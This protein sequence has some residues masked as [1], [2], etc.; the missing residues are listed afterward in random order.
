MTLDLLNLFECT[1]A[2]TA[3]GVVAFEGVVLSRLDVAARR[4]WWRMG[5]TSAWQQA[6]IIACSALFP[7]GMAAGIVAHSPWLAGPTLMLGMAGAAWLD[8]SVHSFIVH[9][10][11]KRT[12]EMEHWKVRKPVEQRLAHQAALR[13]R[14]L[15]RVQAMSLRRLMDPHFLFNALNGIMHDMMTLEWER[16]L[17]H[18]RAFNRLAKHQIQAGHEG[19]RS[20]EDEWTTLQDYIGL[21]VRRLARPIQWDLAP[22]PQ[23]LKERHIPALLVQPLVE[24]ALWHGL[25]GTSQ[26]GPGHLAI[27]AEKTDRD[28][29]TIHVSNTPNVEQMREPE[30]VRPD[31]DTPRRRHA[32]DLIRQRLNL[33]DRSGKSGLHMVTTP[34]KTEVSLIVPCTSS[35]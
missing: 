13:S 8:R 12:I 33:L 2:G 1:A 22:L 21:E 6:A 35:R 30:P 34:H 15:D 10:S 14:E 9:E 20:M 4:K 27:R 23:G 5:L 24:N 19:W 17:H 28:H 16:A 26:T 31:D 11:H 18:L 7:M 29:V 25:G 32:S 3:I